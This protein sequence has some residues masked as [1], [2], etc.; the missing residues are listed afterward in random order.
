MFIRLVKLSLRE[1]KVA[2]FLQLFESR[3]EAIRSQPGCSELKLLREQEDKPIFFTYSV[4]DK[5]SSLEA[6]RNSALFTE[7][8]AKA[9]DCF[10]T[11]AEAW[12]VDE[13][14]L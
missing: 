9:K 10:S 1:D 2:E 5:A 7:V 6:Y 11:K 13:I 12:S 14:K 4:W 3:H 8:W